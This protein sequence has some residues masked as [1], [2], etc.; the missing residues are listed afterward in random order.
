MYKRKLTGLKKKWPSSCP[1]WPYI[2]HS[3]KVKS[4][5]TNKTF[6]VKG[7]FQWVIYIITCTK[8]SKQNVGQAGRQQK[9]R[10]YEHLNAIHNHNTTSTGEHFNIRSS[11]FRN[12]SS[13][14]WKSHSNPYR[15]E[16]K[17]FWIKKMNSK[18][19][20]GFIKID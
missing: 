11:S 1:T 15:L 5:I 9:E 20:I 12:E 18:T 17:D 10:I 6:L 8:C 4:S 16:R 19:P 14:Y 2:H 13:S 3:K 7:Q